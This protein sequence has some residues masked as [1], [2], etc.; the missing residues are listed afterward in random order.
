MPEDNGKQ[1][2]EESYTSK[3]QKHIAYSYGCKLVCVDNKFSKLFKT[4]LGKYVV[5]N[6]INNTLRKVDIN[7]ELQ[8]IKE[9]NKDFK[10]PTKFRSM[11]MTMLMLM[12]K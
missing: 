12:L 9:D 1:N 11:A 6:F 5:Y 10:N 8:M 2:P 3:Y 7:K 4:Y